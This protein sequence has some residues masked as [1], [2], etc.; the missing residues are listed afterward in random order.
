MENKD[1]FIRA[2]ATTLQAYC[3]HTAMCKWCEMRNYCPPNVAP[4]ASE[5]Q[6]VISKELDIQEDS[7]EQRAC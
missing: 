7:N 6:R 1:A 4:T 2:V 3:A 5:W